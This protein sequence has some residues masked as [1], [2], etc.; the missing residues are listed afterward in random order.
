MNNF[1][2]SDIETGTLVNDGK[3]LQLFAGTPSQLAF[4]LLNRLLLTHMEDDGARTF[5]IGADVEFETA[6]IT[7][8]KALTFPSSIVVFE[9][10]NDCAITS[11]M[12]HVV[13][14][15]HPVWAGVRTSSFRMATEIVGML[16]QFDR[17]SNFEVDKYNFA[18][19]EEMVDSL[20]CCSL[21]NTC[22]W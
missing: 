9:N 10:L 15:G 16:L 7:V 21:S 22:S 5:F 1:Y 6:L 2:Q 3:T 13:I 4:A 20:P 17:K 8:K 18:V 14:T 11:L 12:L 19:W